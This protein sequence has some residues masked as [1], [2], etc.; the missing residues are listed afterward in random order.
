MQLDWNQ[1]R[2]F[3]TYA[4]KVFQIDV[5]TIFLHGDLEKKVFLKQPFGFESEKF[6]DHV[7][8]LDKVAYELK[9]AHSAWYDTFTTYPLHNGYKRGAIDNT[10]FIKKSWY[11]IMLAQVYVDGMIFRCMSI[12]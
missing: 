1:I 11:D 12:T 6:L 5:K 3:L 2:L 10:L 4:F 8:K 7:Y 9:Q